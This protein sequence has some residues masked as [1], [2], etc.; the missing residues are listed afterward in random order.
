MI[1]VDDQACFGVYAD[2]ETLPDANMLAQDIDDAITEL[3]AGTEQIDEPNESLL[4]RAHAATPEGPRPFP[5]Q[6]PAP[7]PA[8]EP[9]A[10]ERWGSRTN[11]DSADTGA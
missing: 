10:A 3:L 9:F 5:A 4:L 6:P 1:T 11:G 2:R 7:T 8:Q